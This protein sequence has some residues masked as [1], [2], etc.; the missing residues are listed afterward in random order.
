MSQ[1]LSEP[2]CADY[3]PD[4]CGAGLFCAAFDGRTELTC[5][6]EGSRLDMTECTADIQ[7]ASG[8]CAPTAS[9]CRSMPGAA[10]NDAIGCAKV[11]NSQYVCV[12]GNCQFTAAKLG[13]PCNAET[14]CQ[15][16]QCI[17]GVCLGVEGTTCSDSSD[18]R[19]DLCCN[20]TCDAC[21][22]G[23]GQQC[24]P[25]PFPILVCKP[26]LT[27]CPLDSG[28]GGIQFYCYPSC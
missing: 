2:C 10:C 17:S 26:G 6:A 25:P 14:S 27:C 19:S 4:A 22:Q 21:G 13:D 20:G 23:I 8:V 3:G 5:Y 7:C 16:G 24:T 11:G 15:V 12:G 18:C 28:S 9:K 1:T